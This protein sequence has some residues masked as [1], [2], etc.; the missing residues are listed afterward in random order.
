MKK[1]RI[2]LW[3]IAHRGA[4]EKGP[5]NSLTAF[6]EAVFSGADG[7]EID[8][9]KTMDGQIVVFHD[10]SLERVT[11][12]GR[13][14]K[15][16]D[17]TWD[18]LKNVRIPF[19]GNLL[20]RFPEGGFTR[21]EDYYKN[22]RQFLGDSRTERILLLDEFLQWLV[23]QS[24]SFFA[25]IEYKD[26]QMMDQ[27]ITQIIRHDAADRCILFSGDETV[28]QEIQDWCRKNGKPAGLR[29]GANIRFINEETLEQI[30]DY[31]LYEVGL[32]AGTFG[33]KETELLKV[34]DIRVFSNLGDYPGWWA[35]M[36]KMDISGFKT[37]CLG[38]YKEWLGEN[39]IL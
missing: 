38:T 33:E 27:V 21:E 1:R 9:R 18:E 39:E 7:V 14:G 3:A 26:T 17:M 16:C 25:E 28:I 15:I 11:R 36:Q 6:Q 8:I 4:I 20:T 2:P 30:K 10:D 5:E 31:D 29:L 23:K 24:R 35:A 12:G 13:N 32:N 19:A 34:R 22:E 37:N